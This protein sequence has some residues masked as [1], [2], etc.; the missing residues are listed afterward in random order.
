M[1]SFGGYVKKIEEIIE[2]LNSKEGKTTIK[3][4]QE[5]AD[6]AAEHFLEV[7]K[8]DPKTLYEPITI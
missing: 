3:E 4:S 2:W 1:R 6:K 5:R 7:S 8:V